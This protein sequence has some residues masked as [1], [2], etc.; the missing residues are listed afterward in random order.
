MKKDCCELRLGDEYM[1]V[2]YSCVQ[3][4]PLKVK[5]IFWGEKL[6]YK[7]MFELYKLYEEIFN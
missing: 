1:G 2:Y 4:F 7:K 6:T 3:I 5:D